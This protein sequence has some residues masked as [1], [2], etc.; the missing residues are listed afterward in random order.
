M[1][2]FVPFD[3]SVLD[4]LE[5]DRGL[6]LVPYQV[7]YRSVGPCDLRTGDEPEAGWLEVVV[8]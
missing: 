6:G 3:E 2:V 5:L 7:G 4:C 1:K 8:G